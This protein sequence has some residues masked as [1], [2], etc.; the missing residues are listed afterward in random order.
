MAYVGCGPDT[1][2]DQDHPGLLGRHGDPA[3]PTFCAGE[4]AL[5]IRAETAEVAEREIERF[6]LPEQDLVPGAEGGERGKRGRAHRLF[7]LLTGDG[8]D[9]DTEI[10]EVCKIGM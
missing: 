10:P 6:V 1:G 4:I 5:A 9:G 8:P 2:S 3:C 7:P